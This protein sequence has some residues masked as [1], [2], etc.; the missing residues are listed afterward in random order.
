MEAKQLDDMLKYDPKDADDAYALLNKELQS[1]DR[2]NHLFVR[3][4]VG[5]RWMAAHDKND[6]FAIGKYSS[7]LCAI[8]RLIVEKDSG[9][10]FG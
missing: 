6:E 10:Y 5:R 4:I 8:N 2:D 1:E 7:Y 3:T 9:R